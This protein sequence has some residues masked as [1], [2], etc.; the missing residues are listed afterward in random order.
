MWN[1]HKDDSPEKRTSPESLELC[2]VMERSLNYCH[3]GNARVLASSLMNPLWVS[4]GLLRDGM[5]CFGPA[6]DFGQSDLHDPRIKLPDWPVNKNSGALALATRKT[7]SINYDQAQL[8][9]SIF[10]YHCSRIMPHFDLSRSP[11]ECNPH[12]ALVCRPST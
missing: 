7:H 12:D 11:H 4:K 1:I 3:T 10:R 2:S 5:P 8:A 9:V 6:V